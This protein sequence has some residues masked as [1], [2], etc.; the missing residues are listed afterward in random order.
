M[1]KFFIF[2]WFSFIL[3]SYPQIVDA[4]VHAAGIKQLQELFL[5]ILNLF[6]G[7]VF[8]VLLIVIIMGGFRFLTSGGNKEGL[9]AA[10][11]TLTWGL[12]GILFIVI[13]WLILQLIQAFTGVNFLNQF[14]LGFPGDPKSNPIFAGLNACPGP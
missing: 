12:L 4:Q 8:I 3:L 11:K 7:F 13:G 14:C 10:S 5:R 6:V 2:L 1:K 9:A